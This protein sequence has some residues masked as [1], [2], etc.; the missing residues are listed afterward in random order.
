MLYFPEDF[1]SVSKNYYKRKKIWTEE[2]FLFKLKRKLEYQEERKEFLE[3]FKSY[4][5][6]KY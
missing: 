3:Q 1:Y 4:Y 6:I 5:N 2:V